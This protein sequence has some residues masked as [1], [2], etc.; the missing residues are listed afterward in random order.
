[1]HTVESNAPGPGRSTSEPAVNELKRE[2]ARRNEEAQERPARSERRV[3]RSSSR[4]GGNGISAEPS[5]QAMGS[6]SVASVGGSA[7]VD[8]PDEESSRAG[9]SSS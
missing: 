9:Y 7:A 6:R 2:I 1:M 8:A 3:R 4:T 5:R